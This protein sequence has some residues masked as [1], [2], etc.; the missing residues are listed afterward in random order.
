MKNFNLYAVI[1]EIENVWEIVILLSIINRSGTDRKF[2][3]RTTTKG[4]IEWINIHSKTISQFLAGKNL[5]EV[6]RIG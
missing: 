1:T 2:M 4:I 3:I 6:K 5:P